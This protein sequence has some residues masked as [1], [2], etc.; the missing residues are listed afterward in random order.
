MLK[1]KGL[2]LM[3]GVLI[4]L[5]TTQNCFADRRSYVWTYEYMTMPKGM[6]ELEYYIS[7]ELPNVNKRNINTWKHWLELEYGITDKWDVS[8]YQMWKYLNKAKEGDSQYDGFKLRTRYKIGRKGQFWVDPLI[9]LEYIRDDDFHKPNVIEEKLIFAK[10][11]GGLNLSYNQILKRNLE[12]RGKTDHEYATGISHRFSPNF[13]FGI[14]S[15]G[16]YSKEKYYVGPSLAFSTKKMWISLG[17]AFG[18]N[19]R[20]DDLQ[21]RLILGLPF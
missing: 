7:N 2:G 6:W 1:T 8:M 17:A 12:K 16:N 11:I 9:Y 10:D 3:V 15:K 14:E 13:R 5:I 20:N 19:K 4:I 21:T 18:L